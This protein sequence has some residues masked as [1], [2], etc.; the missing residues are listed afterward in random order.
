V[1]ADTY[2]RIRLVRHWTSVFYYNRLENGTVWMHLKYGP[3][4][5][6]REFILTDIDE[7]MVVIHTMVKN[8]IYGLTL[9]VEHDKHG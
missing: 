2:E 3:Y 4:V 5:A 7:G 1:N 9:D 8:W 6:H